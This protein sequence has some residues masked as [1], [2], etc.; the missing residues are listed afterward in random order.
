MGKLPSIITRHDINK[1]CMP[2][3]DGAIDAF[4]RDIE[5]DYCDSGDW[6]DYDT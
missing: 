6:S 1:L 4:E 3:G 2:I 5:T